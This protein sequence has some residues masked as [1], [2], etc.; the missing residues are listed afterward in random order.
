MA[1]TDEKRQRRARRD[2]HS[3][4][5]QRRTRRDDH[6]ETRQRRTR[7]DDHSETRQRR[8]RYGVIPMT[9]LVCGICGGS[10]AGKTTLTRHLVSELGPDEVCVL[11]F[12][13]YYRDLSHL[14]LAERSRQN[15][16]HPDSIDHE[17]FASHLDELKLGRD[18]EVPVYDFTTHSMTGRFTTLGARSTVI[19]EGILLLAFPEIVERLDL[20]VF[21]DISEPVRLGRRIQRDVVERGR[22]V[23]DVKRQFVETVAPMHDLYVQRHRD[24]ADVI[25]SSDACLEDVGVEL[26]ELILSSRAP[27]LA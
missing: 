6:S 12:D 13:A 21:L 23:A 20:T 10:G 25:V 9:A 2:D 4:T 19:V 24:A 7:R 22:D 3:E 17:L 8:A 18:I 5:R 11:G 26:A 16:D 15:F 1:A 27:E 14:P